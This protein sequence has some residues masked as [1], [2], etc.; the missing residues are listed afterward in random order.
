MSIIRP[1]ADADL[2]DVLEVWHA[3]SLV[4]H[5]FLS[6]DFLEAERQ[7]LANQWLPAS[8]TFVFEEGGHVGG[9]IS[10]VG[11][12]VGGLFVAPDRQGQGVGRRLL[13]HVRSSR[14]VL[15]LNVFEANARALGFYEAYGFVVVGRQVSDVEEQP[16]L[17]L[18]LAA[19][20][21]SDAA[22]P[23]GQ[24]VGGGHGVVEEVTRFGGSP[25]SGRGR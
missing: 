11:H 24:G 5:P 10:M 9:F 17:R 20:G 8:E 13:D 12:E 4:G 16:E 21:P 3:A 18:R 6:D 25:G 19:N 15:E 14:P 23:D 22:E 1:Y 7:R 2:D